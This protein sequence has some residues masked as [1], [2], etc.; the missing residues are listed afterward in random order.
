MTWAVG[1]VVTTLCV[2]RGLQR[3]CSKYPTRRL[4]SPTI[5][6][7]DI[8]CW[9][10]GCSAFVTLTA[11]WFSSQH[12]GRGEDSLLAY[13]FKNYVYETPDDPEW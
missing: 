12:Q 9:Q 13:S 3:R 8:V 2:V 11:V 4:C 6:R 7:C 1:C 10:P 5:P